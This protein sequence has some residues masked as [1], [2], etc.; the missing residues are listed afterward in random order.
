MSIFTPNLYLN[1][2][3]DITLD[4]LQEHGIKG[5]VLDVDNTLTL[6]NSQEVLQ[7]VLDWLEQ[8]KQA[9]ILLT[10]VSN[11]TEK[12][13]APLAERLDLLHVSMGCKPMTMGFTKAQKQFNLPYSQIAVVGDQL[14][15]DILG[16]NIKGMYTILTVPFEME[17][18][19]L[20]KLKRKIEH[21]HIKK[22]HRKKGGTV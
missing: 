2:L 11:N 8:M 9:G 22:Y 13:V 4:L 15:T 17:N 18:G 1:N 10:I 14:Y 20:F 19:I 16:G 5:L 6:H 21:Q 12:R 3:T 7:A